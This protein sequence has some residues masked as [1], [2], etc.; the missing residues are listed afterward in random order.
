MDRERDMTDD[1]GR[2]CPWCGEDTLVR[3]GADERC[4][5]EQCQYEVHGKHAAPDAQDE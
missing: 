1:V 5:A 4:T 3:D 2:R